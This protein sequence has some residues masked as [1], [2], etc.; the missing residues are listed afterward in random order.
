[1]S[2]PLLV[3]AAGGTGGHMF[4]AQALAEAML[5]RGWRV[6]LSTDERGARYAGGFPA[7]VAIDTVQSATFARGSRLDKLRVPLHIGRG[8]LDAEVLARSE[9]DVG[10]RQRA[11]AEL[12]RGQS[13]ARD[14]DV[15]VERTVGEHRNR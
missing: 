15:H 5:R 6:Q 11:V 9:G 4:P 1:M 8:I 7:E 10:L 12:R 3:I 13:C 14:V 2:E